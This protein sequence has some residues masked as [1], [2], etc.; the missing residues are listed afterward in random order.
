MDSTSPGHL[1]HALS[2]PVIVLVIVH[3]GCFNSSVGDA[4]VACGGNGDCPVGVCFAGRCRSADDPCLRIE[5]LA[6]DPVADGQSCGDA[7][8]CR[9][10]VCVPGACGDGF[11]SGIETCD[12]PNDNPADGCDRCQTRVWQANVLVRGAVDGFVGTEVPLS[13]PDHVAV[14]P[15]GRIYLS[16]RQR[17]RVWRLD[18]DGTMVIVAGNGAGA[19][20]GDD[21]P[22][23]DAALH[24]PSGIFADT[25]GRLFIADTLNNRVRAV[26]VDGTIR[27]IAGSDRRPPLDNGDI[28]DGA[29]I[30]DGG[31]ATEA[32]LRNPTD[33]LVDPIGRVWIADLGGR[34]VR[35]VELDGTI[36]TAAGTG[37]RGIDGDGGFARNAR[38]DSPIG[39][40]IDDAG[41]VY[42][43]DRFGFVVRRIAPDGRIDTVA[44]RGTYNANFA[45]DGELALEAELSLP[46]GVA[47]DAEG[48][49]LIAES[50]GTHLRRLEPDGRLHIL[51]GGFE[52]GF[53]DGTAPE[54]IRTLGFSDVDVDADGRI[55]LADPENNRVRAWHE[56]TTTMTTLA[57]SGRRNVAVLG[58]PATSTPFDF[59]FGLA[60]DREGRVLVVDSNAGWLAAV[61]RDGTMT[62]IAGSGAAGSAGD[63]DVAADAP[64]RPQAVAFDSV[65]RPI[66]ADGG[67]F[68]WRIEADGT[69]HRLAGR[70]RRSSVVVDDGVTIARDAEAHPFGI[71][72]DSQD[73]IYFS[74]P[75]THRVRRIDPDGTIHTVVGTG[76]EGGDGDGGPATAACLSTPTDVDVDANDRLYIADIVTHRLRVVD[77]DGTIRTI[78]GTGVPASCADGTPA[79]ACALNMGFT[80]VG[81]A[82]DGT[83]LI[84]ESSRVRAVGTDGIVRT[85]AGG[86]I[87]N[88]VTE[89]GPATDA[90]FPVVDGV[91][92]TGDGGFVAVVGADRII[93][94]VPDGT[95]HSIAGPIHPRGPGPFGRARL[96]GPHAILP[97]DDERLLTVGGAGRMML[98]DLARGV[99]DVV[100]GFDNASPGVTDQARFAPLLEE[101]RGLAFLPDTRTLVVANLGNPTLRLVE[102]DRD[103]DGE[104]DDVGAWQMSRLAVGLVAPAGITADPSTGGFLVADAGAHCVV[105]LDA[106]F[107]V[108]DTIAGACGQPGNVSGFLNAPASAIRSPSGAVYVA[109]TGNHRVLRVDDAGLTTVIGDGSPSSAGAGQPARQFPVRSP[110][111]LALDEHGNLF[112]TSTT[113]VRLIANVDGDV[114]ADGDDLVST[115]F[116]GGERATFPE[117]DALCVNALTLDGRGG[118]FVADACQGFLVRL[119]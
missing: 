86:G 12:D 70:G 82:D 95:L 110:R 115:I 60:V 26:D 52:Y 111:Q 77:V 102:T 32:L 55:I 89:A 40:A 17:H 73:R 112:V 105:A 69:L 83:I 18:G 81:I 64:M 80:S 56:P 101:P 106:D 33:V 3:G 11:I 63:G 108:V 87:F 94:V 45:T 29:S 19:F 1:R 84:A 53:A 79:D 41:N 116:G 9:A 5:G 31:P 113:T 90:S 104:P 6:V 71:T 47:V 15:L 2:L 99:V 68:V 54:D 76:L 66:V 24:G 61:E 8:I 103:A 119:E 100:A 107:A 39:L 50:I 59:V 13:I 10:G 75:E 65:G 78:A 34:R 58:Q 43:A 48:R 88:F 51:A 46:T 37:A 22:A 98:V 30:G 35:R 16:E 96:Y 4:V 23:S 28:L 25:F 42:V 49:L 118:V 21:G 27:T 74:E 38:L 20:G 91:V 93:R 57:G 72:V 44:G 85:V 7:S 14:D 62:H 117:S 67:G 114:D 97:L 92:P 36:V 109:D